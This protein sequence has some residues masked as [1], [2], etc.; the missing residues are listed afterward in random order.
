[1]WF[2]ALGA[3]HRVRTWSLC[4]GFHSAQGPSRCLRQKF[5][6]TALGPCGPGERWTL[7][8]RSPASEHSS[9]QGRQGTHTQWSATV[10]LN[11]AA[12]LCPRETAF[13]TTRRERERESFHHCIS[14]SCE[15]YR[16]I[17]GRTNAVVSQYTF[18]PLLIV[19]EHYT[20]VR[21]INVPRSD[22]RTLPKSDLQ[23][24][25]RS[26][27]QTVTKSDLQTVIKPDLQTVPKSDLQTVPKLDL[28]T[29]S[30]HKY[31]VENPTT[32]QNCYTPQSESE[33]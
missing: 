1:M 14:L 3:W 12:R 19:I 27:L 22:L 23:T 13:C 15:R 2:L 20:H 21:S 4:V 17:S 7:C 6:R 25:P 8:P 18:K 29:Q 10:G 31:Y 11:L 28:Q 24:V 16:V 32:G 33:S 9:V 30:K 26:D 5:G